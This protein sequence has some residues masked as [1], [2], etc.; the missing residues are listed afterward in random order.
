MTDIALFISV[1]LSA[2]SLAWGYAQA[3]WETS[4]GW[5]L[6][7]GAVW[8]ISIWQEWRWFSSVALLASVLCSAFGLVLGFEFSWLLAGSLFALCAWD[9]TDFRRRLRL[10]AKDEDSYGLERRHLARL[11]LLTLAGLLLVSLAL[12]TQVQFTFEWGV[13]LVAVTLI[14]LTQVTGW[15]RK[16]DR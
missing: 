15:F 1:I 7:I 4:A 5:I 13:F 9:L 12:Y 2:G 3:G 10:S 16:Q 6:F 14:G 8:L 11:S